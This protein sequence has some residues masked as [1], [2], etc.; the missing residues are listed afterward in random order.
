VVLSVVS[1]ARRVKSPS[2]TLVRC[3]MDNHPE[4]SRGALAIDADV[5]HRHRDIHR[6]LPKDGTG[7]D[8]LIRR[9]TGETVDP[10]LLHPS[11]H[12]DEIGVRARRFQDRANS[13]V[14]SPCIVACGAAIATPSVR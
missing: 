14:L 13:E 5:A 6:L 4:V 1:A 2:Q 7:S 11:L 10:E 8:S 9:G 12:L 3:R